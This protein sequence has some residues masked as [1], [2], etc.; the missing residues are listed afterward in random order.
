[1]AKTQ[2][3]EIENQIEETIVTNEAPKLTVEEFT[4]ILETCKYPIDRNATIKMFS[5][6]YEIL[7]AEE[8]TNK[9]WFFL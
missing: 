6:D 8:L 7:T 9:Y 1:M 5:E 3:T 4:Q 2:T